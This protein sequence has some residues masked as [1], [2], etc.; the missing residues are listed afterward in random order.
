MSLQTIHQEIIDHPSNAWATALG[1]TPVYSASATANILI[2]GQA[3]GRVAQES[4]VPWNDISG[5]TLRRWLGLSQEQFYDPQTIALVPMDFY[6][7]GKGPSGDL[8][9]RKAFAPLW[10]PRILAEMP[11][12]QLT[13]LIGQYA[14]GYYLGKTAQKNLTETVRHYQDYLP[15]FVPLVHP[16]PLTLRWRS[17]NPW[18]ESETVPEIQKLVQALLFPGR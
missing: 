10:H 15:T 5:D 2:V 9:P 7:P 17:Q 11:D 4:R 8:P 3:P 1:Y 16:S 12:I 18:F 14:Q 13:I 6:Y